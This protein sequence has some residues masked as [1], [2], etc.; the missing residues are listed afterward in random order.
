MRREDPLMIRTLLFTTVAA[1]VLLAATGAGDAQ[2]PAATAPAA[3]AGGQAAAAG[4]RGAAPVNHEIPNERS[5]VQIDQFIGHP[6]NAPAHLSHGGLLIRSMLRQGNPNVPG[7]AGAV[8]EYRT[9]LAIATL[10]ARSSTALMTRER[11]LRPHRCGRPAA[12]AAHAPVQ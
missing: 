11:A 9:Q 1:G 5:N 8:L 7:P 4:G 6:L 2:T 10:P 12:G 3:P